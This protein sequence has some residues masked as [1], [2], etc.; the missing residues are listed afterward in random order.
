MKRIIVLVIGAAVGALFA[1]SSGSTGGTTG[2]GGTAE[3]GSSGDR[4]SVV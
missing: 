3:G 1:C 4:K 2:D